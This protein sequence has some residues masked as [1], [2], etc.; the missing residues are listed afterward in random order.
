[1]ELRCVE[2]L[3]AAIIPPKMHVIEFFMKIEDL[4]FPD[5]HA[6]WGCRVS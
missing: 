6:F 5:R 3:G 2:E 4:D 1:M